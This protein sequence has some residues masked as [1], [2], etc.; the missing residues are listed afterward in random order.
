MSSLQ[1]IYNVMAMCLT[2]L[3]N[4][5]QLPGENNVTMGW[6]IIAFSVM[7]I[8]VKSLLNVAKGI[9]PKSAPK[10]HEHYLMG[11]KEGN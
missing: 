3:F 10:V 11:K 9:Q 2:N 8:T 7:G 1:F 6:V 5:F 4:N